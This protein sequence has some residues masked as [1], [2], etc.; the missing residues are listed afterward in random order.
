MDVK[1][2][3]QSRVLAPKKVLTLKSA[4]LTHANYLLINADHSESVGRPIVG[5]RRLQR[6]VATVGCNVGKLLFDKRRP[7][8]ICWGPHIG[9]RQL[10]HKAA[11]VGFNVGYHK[12]R[13]VNG[14]HCLLSGGQ[15]PHRTVSADT[16][17]QSSLVTRSRPGCS[18]GF[19]CMH[20]WSSML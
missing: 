4:I 1:L 11:M 12:Q 7:P 3:P 17:T 9:S 13:S 16:K 14:A 8:R 15:H 18:P 20:N 6:K 10:Q 2:E 5:S 19:R